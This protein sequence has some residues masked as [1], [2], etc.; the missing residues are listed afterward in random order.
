MIYTACYYIDLSLLSAEF[1]GH[2]VQMIVICSLTI[3]LQKGLIE[4]TDSPTKEQIA[5]RKESLH[6]LSK[7]AELEKVSARKFMK[8]TELLKKA[9]E[10]PMKSM[11]RKI[12]KG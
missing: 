7:M 6:L 12:S 3:A 2:S 4:P 9:T 1:L 8:C 10:E 5:Q 11:Q